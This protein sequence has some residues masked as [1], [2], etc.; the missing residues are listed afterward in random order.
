[1]SWKN[2][3]PVTSQVWPLVIIGRGSSAAYYITSVDLGVYKDVLAIGEDDPWAGARGHAG[4]ESDPTLKINH[5][6]HLI[7][8]FSK[9]IPGFETGL[10]DRLAW[11][12]KNAHVFEDCNVQIEKAKVTLVSESL[13]PSALTVEKQVGVSGYRIDLE[14]KDPIYAYKV[15]MAA[16]GGGHRVPPELTQAKKQW[17]LQVLDLDEFARFD[18]NKF[19]STTRIVVIGPN[20]AIDAVNKSLNYRCQ[21][22]WLVSVG[23]DGKP[24]SPPALATQ[25]DMLKAIDKPWKYN[26]N[27]YHYSKFT[28][29]TQAGNRLQVGGVLEDKKTTFTTA[30][31]YIVYG[32]GG[33]DST[34]NLMSTGIQHKLKPILDRAQALGGGKNVPILGY[35]AEGTGLMS[36]VEVVGALSAQ[37]GRMISNRSDAIKKQIEEVRKDKV[38][39]EAITT[40]FPTSPFLRK[41]VDFLAKQPRPALHKQ[42]NT[43]L[44]FA[45]KRNPSVGD[46]K[47]RL[48]QLGNLILAYHTSVHFDKEYD[49]RNF[50][51]L[52]NGVVSQ[53]PKGTV[54]DSGQLTSIR[55]ALGAYATMQGTLPAY[56]PKQQ[57]TSPGPP[58]NKDDKTFVPVTTTAGSANFNA[59]NATVLQ[60]FICATYPNIPPKQ[61]NDFL[62]RVL[63]ERRESDTGFTDQQVTGFKKELDLLNLKGLTASLS[64]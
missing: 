40:G 57:F 45:V 1:M 15:V 39:F 6:L 16:G 51:K 36:G 11:A 32:L 31:D 43:E 46:L 23:R 17:P 8:H 52:L 53:L 18:E 3:V 48:E 59:D 4:N 21:I 42:M 44:T 27:I 62:D 24:I 63:S 20:A 38:I 54:A 37:V 7:D 61:A 12:Q 33:T 29:P 60:I 9:T 64:K 19:Q 22:E 34:V 50:Q 14:G 49:T 35:E 58:K 41:D 47:E 25:P 10:V 5:P 26:L 28:A 55:S 56:A 30:G 2:P 13:F